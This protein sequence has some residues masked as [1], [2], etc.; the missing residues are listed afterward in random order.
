M[1][2]AQRRSQPIGQPCGGESLIG[3]KRLHVGQFDRALRHTPQGLF[4]GLIDRAHPIDQG[5]YFE[6]MR[7]RIDER[8]QTQ[9]DVEGLANDRDRG[10]EHRAFVLRGIAHPID[11]EHEFDL[12][13]A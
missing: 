4:A 9:I 2:Q 3:L 6:L 1:P 10:G 7:I 8:E 11:R 5:A 12:L 13:V